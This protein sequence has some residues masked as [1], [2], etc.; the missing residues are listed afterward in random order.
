[1]ALVELTGSVAAWA[2]GLNG[3]LLKW[4]QGSAAAPFAVSPPFAATDLSATD[5]TDLEDFVRTRV[6]LLGELLASTP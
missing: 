4:N 5:Y 6:D 1:M 2:N 3:G